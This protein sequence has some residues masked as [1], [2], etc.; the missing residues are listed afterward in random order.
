M[1]QGSLLVRFG[2]EGTQVAQ[3]AA[4]AACESLVGARGGTPGPAD[5]AG[6]VIT[7]YVHYFAHN[8]PRE[9]RWSCLLMTLRSPLV[10]VWGGR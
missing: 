2:F 3:R 8:D 7:P 10:G 5:E 9:N 4:N 6:R 1:T